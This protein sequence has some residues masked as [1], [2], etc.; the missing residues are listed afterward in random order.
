VGGD[1]ERAWA[2]ERFCD[3]VDD[4]QFPMSIVDVA[5]VSLIAAPFSA[6]KQFAGD[7]GQGL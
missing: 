6:S 1:A 7:V 2:R 4:P 5:R 3:L